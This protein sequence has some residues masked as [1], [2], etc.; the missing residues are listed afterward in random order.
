M[1]EIRATT[2]LAQRVDV[3]LE[4]TQPRMTDRPASTQFREALERGAEVI[5][6][7]VEQAA[8]FIPGGS[9]VA[10]AVRSSTGGAPAGGLEGAG[11]G[12]GGPLDA[13]SQSTGSAMQLLALQQQISMEQRQFSTVSNVMK[14]RHETSK[15]VIQNVR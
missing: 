4:S 2:Q 10:A 15:Q 6:S 13:L 7:G 5:V 9:V 1:S 12:A 11:G 14:A 8:G 3:T